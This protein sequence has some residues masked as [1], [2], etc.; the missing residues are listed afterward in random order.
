MGGQR[1]FRQGEFAVN[2]ANSLERYRRAQDNMGLGSI[3]SARERPHKYPV[4]GMPRTMFMIALFSNT[5][6]AA[7]L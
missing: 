5:V 3:I 2:I 1:P 7:N 4:V 6:L